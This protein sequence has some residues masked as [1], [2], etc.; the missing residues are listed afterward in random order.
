MPENDLETIITE[1]LKSYDAARSNTNETATLIDALRTAESG[2]QPAIGR[3]NRY[4][5]RPRKRRL[6][7]HPL[8]TSLRL[9]F[10]GLVILCVPLLF[11]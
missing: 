9:I 5:V 8:R 11:P 6:E 2:P 7:R 4:V 1:F 10:V 3:H